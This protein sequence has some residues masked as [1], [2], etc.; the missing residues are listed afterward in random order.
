[1]KEWLQNDANGDGKLSKSELPERLQS[2]FETY[3]TNKDGYLSKAELKKMA[4]AQAKRRSWRDPIGRALDTD[5]DGVIS[6]D[7]ITNAV[8]A[9]LALDKNGDGQ[10]TEDEVIP[11]FGRRGPRGP[12]GPGREQNQ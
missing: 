8:K 3:D 7:E 4:E 11:S 6:G 1:V 2:Q 12:G 9:L 5:G 10:L